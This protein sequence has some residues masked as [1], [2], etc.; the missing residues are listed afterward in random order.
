M[1][2]HPLVMIE[3]I[4]SASLRGWQDINHLSHGSSTIWSAGYLIKENK[5]DITIS[6]SI[7]ENGNCADA[8]SIPKVAIKKCQ[9]LKYYVAGN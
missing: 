4:D 3:W 2:K 5:T 9:K 8:I 7:T 1:K 6:T